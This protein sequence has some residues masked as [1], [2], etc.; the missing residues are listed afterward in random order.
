MKQDYLVLWSELAEAKLLDKADYI[1]HDSQDERVAEKFLETIHSMAERLSFVAAAYAD[2]HFHIYPL[3]YGHSVKFI[4][5]EDVV[6]I[7]DFLPKG[8]NWH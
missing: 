7:A 8:A 3:K 5:V 1:Y 6:I 4:V 2:R